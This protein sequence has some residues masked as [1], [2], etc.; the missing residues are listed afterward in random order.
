MEK[1]REV[2]AVGRKLSAAEFQEILRQASLREKLVAIYCF[3]WG[4]TGKEEKELLTQKELGR[5][6]A[7]MRDEHW[8]TYEDKMA[9]L[10]RAKRP[11]YERL[12]QDVLGGKVGEVWA[13]DQMT[14]HPL[15]SDEQKSFVALC[16][17][18]SVTV[19]FM[20]R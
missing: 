16:K 7:R 5:N 3:A 8:G 11:E 15:Y 4:N 13:T 9:L 14:L 10:R 2:S 20:M 1:H 6:Y 18:I 17:S 19:S 12:K